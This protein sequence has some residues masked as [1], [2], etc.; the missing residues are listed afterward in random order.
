VNGRDQRGLTAWQ[1]ANI[2][3]RREIAELLVSKG[4]DTGKPMPKPDQIVDAM[5]KEIVPAD[6]PGVA[7]LVARNGKIIFEK[8]YGLASIEQI[9]RFRKEIPNGRVVVFTNADHHCFID[10]EDDV[11]REMRNF[12]MAPNPVSSQMRK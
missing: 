2:Y 6:S 11:V 4:A 1:A 10:R 7:V 9:E 8:G 3:G 5:F 12:L